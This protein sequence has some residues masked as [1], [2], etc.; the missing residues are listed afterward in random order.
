[1]SEPQ[2]PQPQ[3]PEEAVNSD[4]DALKDGATVYL[5]PATEGGEIAKY[6]SAGCATIATEVGGKRMIMVV[7]EESVPGA[8]PNKYDAEASEYLRGLEELGKISPKVVAAWLKNPDHRVSLSVYKGSELGGELDRFTSM[9]KD[10]YVVRMLLLFLENNEVKGGIIMLDDGFGVDGDGDGKI[11][12]HLKN[13]WDKPGAKGACYNMWDAKFWHDPNLPYGADGINRIWWGWVWENKQIMRTLE[14]KAE[15]SHDVIWLKPFRPPYSKNCPWPE[16]SF[17]AEKLDT[18]EGAGWVPITHEGEWYIVFKNGRT[19]E[20]HVV[21]IFIDKY[22]KYPKFGVARCED[23]TS[24][25]VVYQIRII[26][27]ENICPRKVGEWSEDEFLNL[28]EE[29][30]RPIFEEKSSYVLKILRL[31]MASRYLDYVKEKYEAPREIPF[32]K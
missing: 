20:R 5:N 10:E 30:L 24:G 21:W 14:T 15:N 27:N 19:E 4:G 11:E 8:D 22:H 12:P 18:P 7:G 16:Q 17:H 9:L 25:R 6:W 3:Q 1:V 26:G 32:K 2:P 23:M 31:L 13:S 29:D 28:G